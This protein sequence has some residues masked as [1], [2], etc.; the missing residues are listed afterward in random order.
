MKNKFLKL[1]IYLFIIL[2][3]S[4]TKVYAATD[5]FSYSVN[6]D[7]ITTNYT[8]SQ[9]AGAFY[10]NNSKD[11]G[12]AKTFI[13][14]GGLTSGKT[15]TVSRK[16]GVYYVW[17]WET[18][19]TKAGNS[20]VIEVTNSCKNETKT[21]KKGQFTLERC[22]VK[23]SSGNFGIESSSTTFSCAS[24]YQA[25]EQNVSVKE[26]TCKNM[27]LL[28]LSKRYCRVVYNI[29]CV[30]KDGT[31]DD[32]DDVAAATLQSLSVNTGNLSPSFKSGTKKYTVNVGAGTS[33]IKVTAKASSGNTLVSGYGSRTVKLNYGS[34]KVNVKVKNSAGKVTTY[35]IT[36]KR[37]DNRSTVNTLSNL[38]VST[39][40]LTPAFSSD[41]K[42]YTVSV[43]NNVTSISIDATLTDNK[44]KFATGYGPTSMALQLGVNKA[45]IK[46]VS[47]K[48]V[49]NVY[50]ITINRETIPTEC[51]TNTDGLAL[52]KGIKL[53]TDIEGVEI[54]QIE[55]FQSKVFV[56]TDIELPYKVSNLSIDASTVD[57]ADKEHI[58]IEGNNELEVNVPTEVKITVTSNKC[59][60]Y[61]NVYTLNVMRQPEKVLSDNAQLENI[62]IEGYDSFEF[63]PNVSEYKIVIK[64]SDDSLDIGLTPVD[65]GTKCTIDGNKGLKYGSEIS[66]KCTSEDGE[67]TEVYTITVD[68]VEEGPNVFL[69][70]LLVI[71]I[72]CILVYLVLRLLGYKIYFN[73]AMIGSFFR[74]MGE[75]AKNTFDK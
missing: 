5:S 30:K 55:D 43:P 42:S 49:T 66:I 59:P 74:G 41:V 57:E 9:A 13:S 64:K 40:T 15:G 4:F 58:K 35:T 53:Y 31:S 56:Y 33:S 63:K 2:S 12:G 47:E 62:T 50:N 60:N 75:K 73:T 36:V 24:G 48:G 70:I 7:L 65:D 61:S 46:V 29:N 17:V 22:W 21:N 16:N 10:I 38:K 8:G 72:I 34:N 11:F 54:D 69:I 52:L 25:T 18:N 23:D 39:G 32:D 67:N 71:I 27:S 14:Y 68:D 3:F 20:K 37:A 6:G 51:T 19:T 44:S 1:F 45:Y 28:G 26:D